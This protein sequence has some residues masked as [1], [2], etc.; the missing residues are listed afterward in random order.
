[1]V[2]EFAP[3]YSYI[4]DDMDLLGENFN[5]GRDEK[6]PARDLVYEGRL[7]N[8]SAISRSERQSLMK[9]LPKLKGYQDFENTI[10]CQPRRDTK[11]L[12]SR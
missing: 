1:M 9:S 10:V 4:F 5:L 6:K 12:S 3:E 11:K 2:T 7:W 8:S